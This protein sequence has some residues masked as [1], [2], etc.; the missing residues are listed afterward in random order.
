[1]EEIRDLDELWERLPELASKA[2]Y[3]AGLEHLAA[4]YPIYYSENDYPG[5]IIKH[6]P[7]GHREIVRREHGREV[8]VRSIERAGE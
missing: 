2:G 6:Y 5:E 7:D 1:M 8:F 3:E 4:G